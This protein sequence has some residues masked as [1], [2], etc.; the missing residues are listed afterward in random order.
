MSRLR[1]P[2]TKS[3]ACYAEDT[4]Q[5]KPPDQILQPMSE[6][7]HSYLKTHRKHSGLTQAEI[8]FLLNHPNAQIVSRYE[9]QIQ[10]PDL[11]AAFALQVV[12]D[13]PAHEIFEGIFTEIEI[14]I[15]GRAYLLAKKVELIL[16]S[17]SRDRK[18]AFLRAIY[19]KALD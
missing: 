1:P 7:L 19:Q 18:L 4:I 5:E 11:E 14:T 13:V 9:R 12:F 8:A 17:P 3:L 15:Q 16:P 6:P 2:P 10:K